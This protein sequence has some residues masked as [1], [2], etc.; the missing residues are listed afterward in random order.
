MIQI[1]KVNCGGFYIDESKLKIIKGALTKQESAD[2]TNMA[3]IGCGGLIIDTDVFKFDNKT[4]SLTVKEAESVGDT[5]FAPC[6]DLKL[7]TAYFEI[8]ENGKVTLKE[9]IVADMFMAKTKT[10]VPLT[11][12]TFDSLDDFTITVKDEN[13]NIVEPIKDKVYQLERTKL[14]SYEAVSSNNETFNGTITTSSRQAN[15]IQTI[16]F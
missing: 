5:I 8:D 11:N 7:D 16:E 9:M 15:I 13:G 10:N 12:V 4:H 3:L 14:Y 1:E 2:V 6:G